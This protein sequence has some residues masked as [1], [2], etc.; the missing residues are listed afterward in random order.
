MAREFALVR[1]PGSRKGEISC[2]I[3][4]AIS[5]VLW[6]G[7]LKGEFGKCLRRR[8]RGVDEKSK[9]MSRGISGTHLQ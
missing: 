1:G 8:G 6:V 9:N 7:L 2:W 5:V 4:C 3:V